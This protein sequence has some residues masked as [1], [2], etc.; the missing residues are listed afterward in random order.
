MVE[1]KIRETM[2]SI[3]VLQKAVIRMFSELSKGNKTIFYEYTEKLD[4][5]MANLEKE[6]QR[7]K[8]EYKVQWNGQLLPD[9]VFC[10]HRLCLFQY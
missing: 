1:E 4:I 9:S 7:Q 3:N 5:I 6:G 8:Q 10:Y 2:H